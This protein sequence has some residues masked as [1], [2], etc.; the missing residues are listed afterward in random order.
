MNIPLFVVNLFFENGFTNYA[1]PE[2]DGANGLLNNE[3]NPNVI[4]ILIDKF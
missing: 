2:S 4:S 1:H 3:D